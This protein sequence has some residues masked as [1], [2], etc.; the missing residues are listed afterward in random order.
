VTVVERDD[1]SV[2]TDE[3]TTSLDRIVLDPDFQTLKTFELTEIPDGTR[4][5]LEVDG[6]GG[7]HEWRGGKI[8]P[9]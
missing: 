1:G 2:F 3:F 8:V 4:V 7:E 6:T 9:R 5:R